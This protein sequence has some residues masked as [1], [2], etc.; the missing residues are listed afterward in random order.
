MNDARLLVFKSSHT[1]LDNLPTFAAQTHGITHSNTNTI[2][3]NRDLKFSGNC[4]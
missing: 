2:Q 4:R 1:A 3:I